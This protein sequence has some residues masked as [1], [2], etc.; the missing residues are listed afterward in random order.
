MEWSD[1]M[2]QTEKGLD[3]LYAREIFSLALKI[4]HRERQNVEDFDEST[5]AWLAEFR[6][7]AAE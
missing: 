5:S 2:R 3:K 4:E 7:G 1:L 6:K